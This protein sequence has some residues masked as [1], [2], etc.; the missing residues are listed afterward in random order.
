M[1]RQRY[2]RLL[3]LLLCGALLLSGCGGKPAGVSQAVEYDR[4]WQSSMKS[5]LS[6]YQQSQY[7]LA[8]RLFSQAFT[9]ARLMDRAADIATA[10]FNLAATQIQLGNFAEAS[11]TLQEAKSE[12]RR[13]GDDVTEIL[14]LEAR[15]ARWQDN[16]AR[17]KMLVSQLQQQFSASDQRLRPQVQLL[18]GLLACEAGDESLAV[19][20][21]EQVTNSISAN[22]HPA[23]LAGSAELQGCIALLQSQPGKAAEAFDRQTSAL[24]QAQQYRQ[25]VDAL[26]QAGAAYHAAGDYQQ[27]VDR[28]FRAARSAL[29]QKRLILA[30]QLVEE[31][32]DAAQAE[33]SYPVLDRLRQLK[34]EIAA[35]NKLQQ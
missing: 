27:A 24:R 7:R 25:M 28:L 3:C 9:R 21:L 8:E 5:G 14:L 33:T 31:A 15:L 20:S 11:S 35:A 32:D 30:Q 4:Q 1:I 10:A 13:L 18:N 16:V 12:S 23:I 2:F 19:H 34:A 22:S 29:S 17:A 6:A 26:Q